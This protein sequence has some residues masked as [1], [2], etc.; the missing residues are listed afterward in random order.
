MYNNLIL[1]LKNEWYDFPYHENILKVYLKYNSNASGWNTAKTNCHISR[2]FLS[3]FTHKR[4]VN[5]C[6]VQ[7]KTAL[8]SI[9]WVVILFK[10]LL[11]CIISS[12]SDLE[13]LKLYFLI[14]TVKIF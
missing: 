2:T 8:T 7:V 6:C 9:Q 4:T 14:R 12:P 10:P 13:I 11:L 5:E 3:M 1:Q